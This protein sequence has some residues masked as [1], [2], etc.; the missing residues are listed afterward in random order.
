MRTRCGLH[1]TIAESVCSL[2]GPQHK[3][4]GAP[5]RAHVAD[6]P[7]AADANELDTAALERLDSVFDL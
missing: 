3:R 6:L 1:G 2:V 7:R 4:L 5:D